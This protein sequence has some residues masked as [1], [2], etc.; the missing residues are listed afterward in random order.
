[1][2]SERPAVR[3]RP[4][5]LR[6][7]LLRQLEQGSWS[8]LELS[9]LARIPEREVIGHLEHLQRSLRAAGRRMQVEPAECL[10]CGFVYRKRER[11]T[12]PSTCPRCRGQH[13]APPRFSAPPRA[14]GA[15]KPRRS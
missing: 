13:I 5:T 1:M 15:P 9:G 3:E 6:H 2:G 10:G 8:A 4:E 7:E 12:N 11:L 14:E